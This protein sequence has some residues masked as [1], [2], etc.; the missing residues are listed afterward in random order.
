[1]RLHRLSSIMRSQESCDGAL[2]LQILSIY[3][4][5]APKQAHP[6]PMYSRYMFGSFVRFSFYIA[7]A[8]TFNSVTGQVSNDSLAIVASN[9]TLRPW[10]TRVPWTMTISKESGLSM[11]VYR[12]GSYADRDSRN[13]FSDGLDAIRSRI[14]S[15]P[16]W[17]A[18]RGQ[19]YYHA[20]LSVQFEALHP[21]RE[22]GLSASD[23]AKVLE[24][25]KDLF[26]IYRDNPREFDAVIKLHGQPVME[27]ILDWTLS[28]MDFPMDLPWERPVHTSDKGGSSSVWRMQVYMYGRFLASALKGAI[29]FSLKI[30]QTDI[31]SEEG[32]LKKNISHNWY[33]H[34]FVNVSFESVSSDTTE[35]PI[36]RKEA[37]LI[38]GT[39]QW[40]YF[41]YSTPREIGIR[42]KRR[43]QVVAKMFVLFINLDGEVGTPNSIKDHDNND[44]SL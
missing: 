32:S 20:P 42:I 43:G 30:C 10:P 11:E 19:R 21:L 17:S 4:N 36:S 27:L 31:I 1:M 16:G 13:P 18:S 39:V 28:A 9:H 44:P 25:T 29:N 14:Q 26:F 34:G 22:P 3:R 38:I 6:F 12:Y 41:Q 35:I 2:P 40:W 24:T 23:A 5:P 7:S 15:S 33:K 37:S 8:L